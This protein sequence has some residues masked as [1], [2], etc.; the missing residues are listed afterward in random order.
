MLA[1]ALLVLIRV[2][3]EG[4]DL[5]DGMSS[6]LNA[7]MRGRI[8]IGSVD[9]PLSALKTAAT[10]GWVPVTMS[11]V[12][13]WDDKGVSVLKTPRITM[14]VDLHAL[15][16][17]R[18]DFVLRHIVVRGGR[19]LLREMTEP[20]PLHEY[21]TT[22]F[23]LLAAFYSK[24]SVAGYYVGIQATSAPLFDLRDYRIEDVDLEILMK[25]TGPDGSYQFR[26]LLENVVADGFLYMDSSDPIVPKFYTALAPRAS[27]GQIDLFW[28]RRADGTWK[29]DY[30]IPLESATVHQ[31][32]QVPWQWPTSSV[33][34]TLFFD[35][36]LVTSDKATIRVDGAMRDYW[37]DAYDGVWDV[38]VKVTNGGPMLR[39]TVDPDLGGDNV[40][41]DAK[42]TGPIV[43]YPKIDL[44]L[45]GLTYDLTL[46]DPPLHLELEKLHVGYDLVVDGGSVDEFVAR[47]AGGELTISGT[48]GGGGSNETPFMVDGEVRIDQPV[49]LAGRL[50]PCLERAFG[51]KV[52]GN[53]RV[54]RQ[55]GDTALAVVVKDFV[56]KLGKLT[57][58]GDRIFSD[59]AFGKLTLENLRARSDSASGSI[60]TG[61]FDTATGALGVKGRI[62]SGDFPGLIRQV[63]C[64]TAPARR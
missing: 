14:E 35:V 61:T 42:I 43:F 22:V 10:G 8:A 64:A 11:D 12:E 41:V 48:F 45:T 21:D 20:Y 53:L 5:G 26:G 37:A 15:M 47:G 59:V 49:D 27:G 39:H 52:S 19:V 29:G 4:P 56:F 28:S 62:E 57:V 63:Q 60:S 38:N 54:S 30:S 58:Q 6:M 1:G 46:V 40:T 2:K 25:P 9:W 31:L 16:F 24:R 18:H 55:K 51:S 7:K 36:E 34:N 17:G 13:V 32:R 3:F 50:P 44:T 33:A 23:S